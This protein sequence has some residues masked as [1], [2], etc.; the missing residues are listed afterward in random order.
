MTPS[1]AGGVG[2]V[3]APAPVEG[4]AQAAEEGGGAE[5]GTPAR[6]M[7]IGPTQM[8]APSAA[9]A[10][11][12]ANV[13]STPMAHMKLPQ[14]LQN[15]P[16]GSVRQGKITDMFELAGPDMPR[17]G[18]FGMECAASREARGIVHR[19]LQGTSRVRRVATDVDRMLPPHG[20]IDD[21][22]RD[23]RASELRHL[24]VLHGADALDPAVLSR[25]ADYYANNRTHLSILTSFDSPTFPPNCTRLESFGFAVLRADTLVPHARDEAASEGLQARAEAFQA[26]AARHRFAAAAGPAGG[27]GARS[28]RVTNLPLRDTVMRAL[29][30]N[31]EGLRRVLGHMIARQSELGD[32]VFMS[33]NALLDHLAA[34]CDIMLPTAR[35][36]SMITELASNRIVVYEPS[37][38]AMRVLQLPLVREV[39]EEITT[40]AR[41]GTAPGAPAAPGGSG[42][43]ATL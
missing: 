16:G 8:P 30:S 37:L 11:Q 20:A 27:G 33:V 38:H 13:L 14:E 5:Q 2:D 6:S 41:G 22:R 10:P 7:S 3:L 39:L 29:L 18:T 17:S 24:L 25:L 43:R 42:K 19:A 23:A 35:L 4:E 34:S 32:D 28:L 36:R 26:E 12:A 9:G 31:P 21:P 40:N 15:T 1:G